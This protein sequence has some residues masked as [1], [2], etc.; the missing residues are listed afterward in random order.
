[1]TGFQTHRLLI[2]GSLREFLQL[3]AMSKRRGYYTIVCDGY[4]GSE[5]K[6][7]ADKAYD[8]P[9]DHTDEIAAMCRAEQVDGIITSFS[10]FLFECMVK[11]AEK[12]GLKCYFDTRSLP[13]YRNKAQMKAM[14]AG[15][16]ISTPACRVVGETFPDNALDGLR[17]PVVAKP[18][19]KYGSRGVEV[20]HSPQE[21]RE[22][23]AY[24]CAT[25]GIKKVLVEE[26]ND[27]YEFNMM[28]WVLHGKVQVISIADRE[29]TPIGGRKIPISTR[30][31]YPSRFM[32]DVYEEALGILQKVAGYT[33]QRS[34]ALSMQFFWK[35]GVGISVCEVAGRFLGYEH[36]LVEYAG[37]LNIEKLLLD[38]VYEEDALDDVFRSYSPFFPKTSAALY[39]HGKPG[40]RAVSW[41][42]AKELAELPGVK[43]TWLFYREGEEVVLHGPNPYAARYYITGATREEIDALTEYF[44]RR[45]S[46]TDA[47]GREV[48]YQ[49]QIGSYP[50]DAQI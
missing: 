32:S 30:N 25:S 17:F 27:G 44:F 18:L 13:L 48:L 46:I 38:Y 22:R 50:K 4:P 37:G 29:K 12:A 14:L 47:D 34:G 43:E 41:P 10:D 24:T 9:V 1:M 3:I 2:L 20:L 45:M 7:L 31:V 39:F 33:G 8:I 40:M 6:K 35:P 49:N 28:T 26:Y 42:A 11:I 16:G 36:E 19:D 23:F 5:G 15:L 21:V